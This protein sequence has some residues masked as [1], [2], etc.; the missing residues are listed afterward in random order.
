[1]R[2]RNIKPGFYKNE[3]LAECDMAARLLFSG[4][5][6]MAD[7]EGRM[8]YRP[9]RIK[10]ELL[11]YDNCNVEKLIKQL[12]GKGFVFVYEVEGKKYL[13][14]PT[15]KQHQNCHVREPASTVPAPVFHQSGKVLHG[16]G[17]AESPLLNPPYPSLNPESSAGPDTGH[18]EPGEKENPDFE[19]PEWLDKKA[20]DEYREHRKALK[21]QMTHLAEQKAIEALSKFRDSGHD[22]TEIINQSIAMG[23]KGLF[24]PKRNGGGNGNRKHSAVNEFGGHT[25][26]GTP[27]EDIKW[28]NE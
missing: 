18:D 11:P 2:A 4:L 16:T 28:L 1:M 25:Y 27:A 12:E 23:W 9:K 5:W 26:V 21:P 13:S 17:P 15:F 3:D 10:A 14:I 24:E 8:E 22:P 6:C 20:W 19:L 7:R